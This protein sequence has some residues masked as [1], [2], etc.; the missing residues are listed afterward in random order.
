MNTQTD[1]KRVVIYL[2]TLP[3]DKKNTT[4]LLKQEEL[5]NEKAIKEGYNVVRVFK[6]DSAFSDKL[7]KRTALLQLLEYCAV[8]K[9]R[10]EAVI[11][12]KLNILTNKTT[13][14]L[15]IRKK[16]RETGVNLISA[17]EPTGDSSTEKMIETILAGFA[18][19]DEDIRSGKIKV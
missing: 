9:N 19:L 1:I 16:L 18:A 4:S 6:E 5:C 10:I 8:K 3:E 7:E 12:F 13:E 15:A 17:T 11:V 2:R 14:Y